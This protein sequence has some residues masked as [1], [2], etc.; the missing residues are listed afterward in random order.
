M[1]YDDVYLDFFR[2]NV[3]NGAISYDPHDF[4]IILTVGFVPN[5]IFIGLLDYFLRFKNY[6]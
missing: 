1:I 3:Q 5:N 6:F 4:V 2:F